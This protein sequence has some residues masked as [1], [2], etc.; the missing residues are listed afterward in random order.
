MIVHQTGLERY[1]GLYNGVHTLGHI[2]FLLFPFYFLYKE[3]GS[4]TEK[5]NPILNH[6]FILILLSSLICLYKSYVRTCWIGL[7]ILSGLYIASKK[8][9][10]IIFLS[11]SAI[12][13]FFLTSKN[14]EKAFHDFFGVIEGEEDIAVMGS[15]R[16]DIWGRT[17]QNLQDSSL[18]EIVIGKGFIKV[19]QGALVAH[20]HNDFLGLFVSLGFIGLLFYT[21][22]IFIFGL[23]IFLSRISIGIR[24]CFLGFLL[25]V[26]SMNFTS[27]SYLSRVE[28]SQ[29]FYFIMGSYYVIR[30]LR[31]TALSIPH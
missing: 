1:S 8:K 14:I 19:Q 21:L 5:T 6:F 16:I 27:N 2:S 7:L 26:V 12:I 3:T 30:D 9:Y 23:D 25:A 20:T 22:I 15:G 11:L 10:M 17:F 29:Y 24:V 4:P 18:L 13:I 28:I 31:K